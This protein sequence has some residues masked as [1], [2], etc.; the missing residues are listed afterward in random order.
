MVKESHV[1]VCK[2]SRRRSARP[3]PEKVFEMRYSALETRI[4]GMFHAFKDVQ[5]CI[6]DCWAAMSLVPSAFVT[7]GKLLSSGPVSLQCYP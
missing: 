1:S 6:Y 3:T 2:C 7:S 5:S 4:N